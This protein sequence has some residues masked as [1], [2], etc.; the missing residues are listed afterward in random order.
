MVKQPQ[1]I[2]FIL[3]D[4]LG[5]G[6]LS[7]YGAE[8][9]STPNI[10]SLAREGMRFSDAHSPAP[11]C[12]PSRYNLLTGRYCWRTW[13]GCGCVWA[14]DPLLID[15]GQ[16][17]IASLL[18][19]AGY[20]TGMVG[21]WH[22]GFGRPD[23]G[24]FDELMG[25]D[26]NETLKPGPNEVGFDYFYG[27]PAVGQQ[28]NV[29]I[30]NGKVQHIDPDDPI[31][32]HYDNRPEFHTSYDKRPR[33][34]NIRLTMDSGQSAEYDFDEGAMI[35]TEKAVSFIEKNADRPFFLYYASRN[36]HTPIRPHP[37]FQ[38]TSDCGAYGD[39]IHEL[40]WSV[41]EILT[42]LDCLGLRDDTLVIFSS[43]NGAISEGHRPAAVVDHH[44]HMACGPLRG[45]KSEIW[46]GGHRVPFIAR[47]PGRIQAGSESDQLIALTDMLATFAALTGQELP[48][49]AGPD[50]FDVLPELLGRNPERKPLRETLVNDSWRGLYAIRRG[51]WKLITGVG[52]GGIGW[53]DAD[54]AASRERG[55]LYNLER[56]LQ[57]R[58]DLYDQHPDIVRELTERM[59]QIKRVGRSR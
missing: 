37:Q 51:P 43:D 29:M 31:E 34:D 17:T 58:N 38:G 8:K 6:D 19:S 50:S 52:G 16:M 14:N 57:E 41:G 59:A 20:S 44:G 7:C 3:A 56:D 23:N 39:F 11:I 13:A 24:N 9:V 28:P 25:L 42:T 15:D 40:D 10:D 26:F 30:E 22:L 21:K 32:F 55:Q 18:K 54:R 35:L 53:S 12:T 48:E 47:W 4:D 33:T 5:Y 1:N 2:V 49:D 36:I 27:M 45:Q 46:E